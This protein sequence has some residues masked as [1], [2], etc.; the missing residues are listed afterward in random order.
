M[1]R[2]RLP[3]RH[4]PRGCGSSSLLLAARWSRRRRAE[5]RGEALLEPIEKGG[6]L[7]LPARRTRRIEPVELGA[8]RLVRFD[9]LANA[10]ARTVE[11]LRLRTGQLREDLREPRLKRF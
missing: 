8:Y 1:A 10:F 2:R 3:P 6:G 7:V 4:G 11:V 9:M 5:L